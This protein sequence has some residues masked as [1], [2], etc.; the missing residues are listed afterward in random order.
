MKILV[1]G[2]YGQLGRSLNKYLKSNMEIFWTGRN[3]P[4]NRNAFYLDICDRINLKELISLHDPDIIINLAALTDVDLCEKKSDLA[5]EINTYGVRNVCDTFKGKI[6][7]LSTDYVFDGKNGPYDEEDDASPLSVYGKTKLEAEKI[8]TSHNPDNLIIRG[9]VLYDN[10]LDSRASF[11]NWVVQS[12]K[13][14][15]PINV[16]DDQINNP[17]WAQSMAK[18]I[19]LCIEKEISG[20]YHWGDAEFVSRYE[21]A[22]MIA[23][24]YN[25]RTELISPKSTKELGQVAPRPLK[26]GLLSKRIVEKLDIKQPS[27]N[28]CLNQIVVK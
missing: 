20:I 2:S 11:L 24:H 25:L 28:E 7:Q 18:I 8:V 22:K 15:T 14:K 17:T 5:R 13:Q 19:G 9:N 21:F 16:V 6:I 3:I 4:I 12:L 27:I 26:S 10:C 23:K 1:T